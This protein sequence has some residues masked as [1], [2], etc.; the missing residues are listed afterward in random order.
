MVVVFVFT[1]GLE[2]HG[3]TVRE[4]EC[5]RVYGDHWQA[6]YELRYGPVS[7]ARKKVWVGSGGIVAVGVISYLI[8]RQFA[9]N[10]ANHRA[11]RRRSQG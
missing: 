11:R 1:V 10:R 6:E 8:Y 5:K 9:G 2:L 4:A 3:M 7:E